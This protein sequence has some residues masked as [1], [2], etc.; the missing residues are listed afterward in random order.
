MSITSTIK[1]KAYSLFLPTHF[2][3]RLK[4]FQPSQDLVINFRIIIYYLDFNQ[5]PTGESSE[6]SYELMKLYS[7]LR[8]EFLAPRESTEMTSNQYSF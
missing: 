4:I 7:D 5:I 6:E 1:I 8:S 3:P 2:S